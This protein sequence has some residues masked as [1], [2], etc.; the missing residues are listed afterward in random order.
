[1]L[2]EGSVSLQAE[3]VLAVDPRSSGVTIFGRARPPRIE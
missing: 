3:K 2:I 1:M